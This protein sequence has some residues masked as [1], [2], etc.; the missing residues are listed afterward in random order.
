MF[1]KCY[2]H[3]SHSLSKLKQFHCC[4]AYDTFESFFWT[5]GS[6]PYGHVPKYLLTIDLPLFSQKMHLLCFHLYVFKGESVC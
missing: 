2:P 5:K 6:G 1:S 3:I 4:D